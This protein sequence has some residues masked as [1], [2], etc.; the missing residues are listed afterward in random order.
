V[1]YFAATEEDEKEYHAAIEVEEVPKIEMEVKAW[2][3]RDV[4]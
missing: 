4:S 2:V 3:P 1:R